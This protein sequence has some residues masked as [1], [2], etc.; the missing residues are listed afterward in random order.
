MVVDLATVQFA[1][2]MTACVLGM[3]FNSLLIYAIV[4]VTDSNLRSYSYLLLASACF[5]LF[6]SVIEFCTLHQLLSCGSVLVIMS[7][8]FVERFLFPYVGS[9]LMIPHVFAA[10][11][12]L[13]ILAAQF[14]YR[15]RLVADG[16]ASVWI[17]VRD[18]AITTSLGWLMACSAWWGTVISLQRP[19]EYYLEMI[20]QQS[21][22]KRAA[23][24]ALYVSDQQDTI[25]MIYFKSSFWFTYICFGVSVYY[26][27][28]SYLHV[29]ANGSMGN[30]RTERLQAQFTR[31]LVV[32]TVN[33][34][35]FALIPLSFSSI[36]MQITS[37]QNQ[38]PGKGAFE[39]A[40]KC[41]R[42]GFITMTLLSWLATANACCTL[43]IVRKYRTYFLSLFGLAHLSVSQ[44]S[45]TPD[46]TG[47]SKTTEVITLQ[48]AP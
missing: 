46:H 16:E 8:G 20:N 14:H 22:Y 34:C 38:W 24:Y 27:L 2:D 26:G 47:I 35:I 29:R 23:E 42:A 3:I 15:Y 32:Q 10:N 39:C 1:S 19:R 44:T 48:A 18:L 45:A 31:S 4:K 36:P 12:G 17:L 40:N 7:H 28:R 41:L 25:T 21:F 13:M 11:H 33:T 9:L 43:F 5:D 6:F 37:S 30:Q